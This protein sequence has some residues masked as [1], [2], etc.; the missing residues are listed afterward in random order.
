LNRKFLLLLVFSVFSFGATVEISQAQEQARFYVFSFFQF[1][2]DIKDIVQACGYSTD[3]YGNLVDQAGNTIPN[4][5]LSVPKSVAKKF[6]YPKPNEKLWMFCKSGLMGITKVKKYEIG[7]NVATGEFIPSFEAEPI[8]NPKDLM[9]DSCQPFYV[10]VPA[11]TPEEQLPKQI[12]L[13]PIPNEKVSN[14][15]K[16]IEKGEAE[17]FLDTADQSVY[18]DS[19]KPA[20]TPTPDYGGLNPGLSQVFPKEN[21]SLLNLELPHNSGSLNYREKILV[22]EVN[23]KLFMAHN[24]YFE[25]VFQVMGQDYAVLEFTSV[26]TGGTGEGLYR[27]DEDG[28]TRL[29]QESI[30][31]D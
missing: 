19:E 18:P 30:G 31:D 9:P 25:Q 5:I 10:S 12:T 22:C 1:D 16:M 28:L 26:G 13:R 3:K 21:V 4:G 8:G 11:G 20:P 15:L 24:C 2:G 27:V 14:I 6:I 17:N 23:D 7:S 29:S